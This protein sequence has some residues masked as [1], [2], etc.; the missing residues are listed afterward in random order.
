MAKARAK[1][2]QKVVQP[3]SVGKPKREK[4]TITIRGLSPMLQHRFP[5]KTLFEFVNKKRGIIKKERDIVT[6]VD[7]VL[8]AIHFIDDVDIDAL[9]NK[10]EAERCDIGSDITKY[11]K[12]IKIGFPSI[13]VKLATVRA[14]KAVPGL[15]MIDARGWIGIWGHQDPSLAEL[16]YKKCIMRCDSVRLNNG[17]RDSRVRP[18]FHD[19]SLK[20]HVTALY[21]YI[22]LESVINLMQMGGAIAGIGDWRIIC[23]GDHGAFEV[24]AGR[25][26]KINI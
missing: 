22:S 17:P 26:S 7:D 20:L 19:W 14:A 24:V 18:E 4:A 11:F 21:P 12:K 3:I 10:M 8:G 25:V 2:E 1:A 9:K 13:G 23:N 6:P 5:D 15:D 16:S